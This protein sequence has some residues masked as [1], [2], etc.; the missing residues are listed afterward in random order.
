MLA[1]QGYRVPDGDQDY[2]ADK[3]DQAAPGAHRHAAVEG[4]RA[5]VDDDDWLRLLAQLRRP[6]RAGES[7]GQI[8]LAKR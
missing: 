1:E 6:N 2:H 4:V 5:G 8:S 7:N 3:Q